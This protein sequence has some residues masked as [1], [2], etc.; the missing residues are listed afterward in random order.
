MELY[1]Q[2]NIYVAFNTYTFCCYPE[3]VSKQKLSN[4]F[5]VLYQVHITE[6]AAILIQA[7][8]NFISPNDFLF[9]Y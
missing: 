5:M 9:W 1:D 6:V 2:K 3:M 4:G 8:V 7:K